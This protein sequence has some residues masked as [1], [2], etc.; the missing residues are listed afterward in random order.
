MSM[1]SIGDHV[2]VGRR[3]YYHCGEGR[4]YPGVTT[5]LGATKRPEDAAG[6]ARWRARVGEEEAT[7]ISSEA[8]A[9][10]T[11]V[12][13][14]IESYLAPKLPQPQD[15]EPPDY[16][17]AL[18]GYWNS[19]QS[20][21]AEI[22]PL[23]LEQFVYS[24]RHCYAGT[25]DCLGYYQGK[26]SLVDFKTSGKV[27]PEAY[28][29]DWLCQVTAYAAASREIGILQDSIAQGV[30]LVALPDQ[31]AQVFVCPREELREYWHQFQNRVN[32]FYRQLEAG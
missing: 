26:L 30:I 5:I 8:A 21:I 19:I 12:H 6:L 10:G 9:R 23:Y 14:Q 7:R 15:R 32:K 3:R 29:F 31:P 17:P 4:N 18:A 13:A 28:T 1:V 11:Y 24:D 25:M 27:K 16:D 20:A 22:E 2:W